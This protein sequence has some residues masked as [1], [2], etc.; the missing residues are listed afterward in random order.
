MISTK[1]NKDDK[2]QTDGGDKSM[3]TVITNH[4][5]YQEWIN[6]FTKFKTHILTFEHFQ[7]HLRIVLKI[8]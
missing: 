1:D 3:N 2:Q 6:N 5:Y 8:L 7:F 4:P